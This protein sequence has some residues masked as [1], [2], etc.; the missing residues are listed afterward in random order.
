MISST[1]RAT[2]WP[3]VVARLDDGVERQVQGGWAFRG[4][5]RPDRGAQRVPA[6]VPALGAVQHHVL[7]EQST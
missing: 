7:G 6:R 2:A 1:D 4:P 3:S 5:D